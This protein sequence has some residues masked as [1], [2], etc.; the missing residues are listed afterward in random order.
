MT[1]NTI[2]IPGS[3]LADAGW[4]GNTVV[5]V[6]QTVRF[7]TGQVLPITNFYNGPRIRFFYGERDVVPPDA[8][9]F[10]YNFDRNFGS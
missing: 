10:N 4:T 1:E 9:G 8:T 5:A 6:L 7:N 2:S 3:V